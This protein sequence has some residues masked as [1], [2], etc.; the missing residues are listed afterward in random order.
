MSPHKQEKLFLPEYSFELMRIAHGDLTSAIAIG[1]SEKPRLENAFFMLQ[2]AIEKSLKAVLVK[3]SIPVPLVHDLGI[4]LAKLPENL[5]PPYGYELS[6]LNQ[7]AAIR[8][9]EEGS[10]EI[11]ITDFN[12]VLS[13]T[14]EML[15]WSKEQIGKKGKQ[16]G[17]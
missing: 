4:L 9:Y 10:F 1:R 7:Y 6:E 14:E 5:N 13:M 8:R 16:K 11:T 15:Q 2:Q 3:S 12:K 17:K